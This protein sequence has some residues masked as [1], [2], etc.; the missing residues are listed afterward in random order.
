MNKDLLY[1]LNPR[2]KAAGASRK[3]KGLSGFDSASSSSEDEAQ[4]GRNATNK[5]IVAE[6]KAL[7]KR[8]E[9]AL[10]TYDF[11]GEYESFTKNKPPP[12]KINEDKSS[13]Y[14]SKLLESSKRRTREQ[15]IIYERQ[16]AKEQAAEDEKMQYEGKEKFITS[17]YKRKL[18]E[19]EEWLKEEQERERKEQDEDVT[20]KSAGGSFL[21]AGF[22]RNILSAAVGCDK[23]KKN[24]PKKLGSNTEQSDD[25]FNQGQT[26][27]ASFEETETAQMKMDHSNKSREARDIKHSNHNRSNAGYSN[28]IVANNSAG[29]T[30]DQSEIAPPKS[31]KQTL[32]ERAVKI[33]EARQRYFQRKGIKPSQW[34]W[35]YARNN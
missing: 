19:R 6:Q 5:A 35:T 7:R 11:D 24:Q 31:R 3:R 15:E 33:R 8:A 34:W 26:R 30:I 14:I 17:S 18:A 16:I 12:K 10:Q 20:K 9:A 4:T 21:F 28:S 22:G 23:D 13:K 32:E 1:G 29:K 27:D 2:T 25:N